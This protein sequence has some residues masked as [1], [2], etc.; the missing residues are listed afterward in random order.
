MTLYIQM[1]KAHLHF[2]IMIP[3]NTLLWPSFNAG[4]QEQK[5]NR[6]HI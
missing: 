6:D 1:V 2:D 4:T 5:G 3:C